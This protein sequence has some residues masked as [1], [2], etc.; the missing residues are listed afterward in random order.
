VRYRR[1]LPPRGA[2]ILRLFRAFGTGALKSW[3]ESLGT[4][5]RAEAEARLAA[6]GT[7]F[8]WTGDGWLDL[9]TVLPAFR[10]DPATGEP[11]WFNQIANVHV[12][13]A[14][15]G[16]LV[17]A[18]HAG[19][20]RLLGPLPLDAELGD[21]SPLSEADAAGIAAAQRAARFDVTL[22]QGDVV[23]FDNLRL[24]HG[25]APYLGVREVRVVFC[26]LK[27]SQP[28]SAEEVSP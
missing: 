25:R 17:E 1:L 23:W 8:T 6:Q 11:L 27:S 19:G 18:L 15:Y 7:P 16:R 21:G 13:R 28:P 4:E 3:Q 12:T 22:E 2:S 10:A 14:F 24:S 9:S 5:D 26:G 20:T